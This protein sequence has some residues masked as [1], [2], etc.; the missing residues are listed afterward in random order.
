[1]MYN[2]LEVSFT[3]WV[4]FFSAIERWWRGRE[5]WDLRVR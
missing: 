5:V 3:L 2:R 4:F 1:M